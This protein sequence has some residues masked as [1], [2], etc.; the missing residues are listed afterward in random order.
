MK[1]LG[2]SLDVLESLATSNEPE[3]GVTELSKRTGIG[4]VIVHNILRTYLERGYVFQNP[5]TKRYALGDR[6]FALMARKSGKLRPL[7]VAR[8]HMRSLSLATQE[9]I[10]FTVPN[11]TD[12]VVLEIVESPQPV[13]FAGTLGERAPLHCTASGKLFLAFGSATLRDRVLAGEIPAYTPHTKTSALELDLQLADVRKRG[14]ATDREEYLPHV[15]AVAA[16]V[17][18]GREEL[19][20]AIAVLGP[21]L[22]LDEARLAELAARVREAAQ[23]VSLQLL[24]QANGHGYEEERQ[25]MDQQP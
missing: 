22:R 12:A 16:P 7:D 21:S 14:Y 2:K 10:H 18:N 8:P 15:S 4:K 3:L 17:F 20:G 9:T 5:S 13:R 24:A 23:A 11:S 6:L 25:P 1:S 19:V